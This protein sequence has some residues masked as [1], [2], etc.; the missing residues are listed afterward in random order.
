[1]QYDIPLMANHGLTPYAKLS[2][3]LNSLYEDTLNP[4]AFEFG[5]KIRRWL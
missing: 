2:F 3:G 4:S 1:M 5:I